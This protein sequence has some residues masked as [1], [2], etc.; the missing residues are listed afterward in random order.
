MK[1]LILGTLGI[2]LYTVFTLKDCHNKVEK[3]VFEFGIAIALLFI[4]FN[5]N[6]T[7][8]SFH[9]Y[10]FCTVLFFIVL[11]IFFLPVEQAANENLNYKKNTW[12]SYESVYRTAFLGVA[13]YYLM[14]RGL[15][16]GFTGEFSLE[17]WLITM[18]IIIA[19]CVVD[20]IIGIHIKF[21]KLIGW[22]TNLIQ[23]FYIA[24]F[25]Y[26]FVALPEEFLYRG[27]LYK[28]LTILFPTIHH[29]ILLFLS[30]IFFGLAHW[31][32]GKMM[33]LATIAGFGYGLTYIL[34]NN[35][36]L[37]IGTHL[38]VNV[39]WQSCFIPVKEKW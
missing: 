20:T 37:A 1:L 33:L 30:S 4:I 15:D 7:N 34:T 25:M 23:S 39:Y 38:A 21:F 36:Y 24:V 2:I 9:W 8:I 27:L 28:Y 35:L 29:L 13:F 22:K 12:I 18:G 17:N 5:S 26:F 32:M 31:R 6:P 19:I 10:D 11:E 3:I 14:I 16:V